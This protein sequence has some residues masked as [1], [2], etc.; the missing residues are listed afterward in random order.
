MSTRP[1]PVTFIGVLFIA[2]GIL[3]LAYHATELDV[4]HLFQDDAAWVIVV[5]LLAIVGGAFVLRG[6]NWA[7]WLLVAWAAYH[8]ALS[9]FHS[10][11]GLITHIVVLAVVS[12]VLFRPDASAYFRG[13]SGGVTTSRAAS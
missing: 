8:V 10:R 3:G 2:T 4:R 11:S 9:A 6:S 12:W 13:A 7:R 1:G 5:R